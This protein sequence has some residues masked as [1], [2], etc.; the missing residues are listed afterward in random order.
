METKNEEWRDIRGF[1]GLY[2]VSNLGRVRSLDR[3]IKREHPYIRIGKIMKT[4]INRY[5]YIRVSLTKKDGKRKYYEVH[6]LV[7]L[8]F[9]H[10]YKH[11][12]V[13]NHINEI[14]TDNRA[15][16]LEWCTHQYNSQHAVD[17]GLT[18]S[19]IERM[20]NADC[21][22]VRSIDIHTNKIMIFPSIMEA[23]RFL[24]NVDKVAHIGKVANGKRKTAYG[25]KWEYI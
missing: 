13:V 6:R 7:A 20:K 23:A 14:K 2:Q 19:T 15:E 12:L 3:I 11:D 9:V 8:H 4:S 16:N 1:E 10:G 25:Y 5:G 18:P 22:P 17:L 24:G 21:K